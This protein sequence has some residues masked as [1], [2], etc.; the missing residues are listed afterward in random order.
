[1]RTQ[2]KFDNAWNELVRLVKIHRKSFWLVPLEEKDD[3]VVSVV[4]PMQWQVAKG[5]QAIL[6]NQNLE[7]VDSLEGLPL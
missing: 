7:A 2:E 3:Y 6:Y 4:K 5:A 1:M